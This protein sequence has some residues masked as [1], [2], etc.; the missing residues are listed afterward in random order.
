MRA[1]EL[2]KQGKYVHRYKAIL[3]NGVS[4]KPTPSRIRD[5]IDE[6][7]RVFDSKKTGLG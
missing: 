1:N 7:D 4:G 6:W 2:T 5:E 3:F